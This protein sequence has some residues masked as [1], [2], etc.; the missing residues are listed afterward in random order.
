MIKLY[1]RDGCSYCDNAK[2]LLENFGT[3]YQE[4]KIGV[5][6][7]RDSVVEMFPDRKVLPIIIDGDYCVGGYDDLALY[8]SKLAEIATLKENLSARVC[9]V[10]FTKTSGEQRV[11]NC[12][13][14]PTIIPTDK[15]PQNKRNVINDNVVRVF[16]IDIN[17][18]RSFK[19]QS[20]ISWQ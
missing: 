7:T 20:V 15:H 11:I 10:T 9:R 2:A 8:V 1:T 3:K 16:D 12:T 17:E 13:T 5:D 18:W 6:I 19:K 14:S 4:I